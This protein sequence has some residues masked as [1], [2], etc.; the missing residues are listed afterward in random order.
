MILICIYLLINDVKHFSMFLFAN[1]IFF[2][3]TMFK[4]APSFF[5]EL[6]RGFII[7]F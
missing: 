7:T 2:G 5:T 1:S 6:F 3:E 4:S